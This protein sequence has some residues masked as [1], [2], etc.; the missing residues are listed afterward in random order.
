MP[1]KEF[2]KKYKGKYLEQKK[3]YRERYK[4]KLKEINLIRVHS[5]RWI[6]PLLISKYGGCQ[7]CKSDEKLEIHHIKY[8]TNFEDL[9]LLCRKCHIDIHRRSQRRTLKLFNYKG[10]KNG[11]NRNKSNDRANKKRNKNSRT[12]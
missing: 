9:M 5:I 3:R 4:D 8:T 7:I 12:S 10:V 2:Y 1:T 11:T 6:K